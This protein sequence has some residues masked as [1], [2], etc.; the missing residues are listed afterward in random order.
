MKRASEI[1]KDKIS[2]CCSKGILMTDIDLDQLYAIKVILDKETPLKVT[3]IE[4]IK[5]RVYLNEDSFCYED[6][7]EGKCPSCGKH[8]NEY[9][10]YCSQCGQRL[11]WSDSE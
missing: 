11:D 10:R 1:V 4:K 2:Y 3:D 6:I 8:L 7:I 5:E 9:Y